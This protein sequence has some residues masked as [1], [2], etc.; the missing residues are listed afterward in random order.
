[1]PEGASVRVRD[2]SQ[3]MLAQWFSRNF[4]SASRSGNR[5]TKSKQLAGRHGAG[6]LLLDTSRSSTREGGE[7]TGSRETENRHFEVE[8]IEI[9]SEHRRIVLDIGSR[10][11]AF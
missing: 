6:A 1:M 8:A 11:R 5:R 3:V 9:R 4:I 10:A 7:V 2:R